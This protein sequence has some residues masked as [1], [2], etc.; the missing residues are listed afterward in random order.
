MISNDAMWRRWRHAAFIGGLG[1][2]ALAV[3]ILLLSA[4]FAGTAPHLPKNVAVLETLRTSG[5]WAPVRTRSLDIGG[6]SSNA[7]ASSG[8]IRPQANSRWRQPLDISDPPPP[9]YRFDRTGD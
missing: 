6:M 9:D 3:M 1:L 2:S 8:M 5:D 4:Y 7:D